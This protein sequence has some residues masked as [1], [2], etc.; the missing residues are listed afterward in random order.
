[1]LMK[2]IFLSII[3]FVIFSNVG[4]SKPSDPEIKILQDSAMHYYQN[5]D[6]HNAINCYN[7][8]LKKGYI[9]PQLYYNIGNSYYKIEDIANA[10]YFY[11]KA[12]LLSPDNSDIIHNLNIANSKIKNKV[13]PIPE[14]FFINWNKKFRDT[15][16]SNTW[17]LLSIILFV[18]SLSAILLYLFSKTIYLKKTGFYGAIIILLFSLIALIFS[19]NQANNITKNS[20]AIVFDSEIVKSSPQEEGSNLFEINEGLKVQ[21][22]DSLNS[23]YNIKLADGKQGWIKKSSVKRL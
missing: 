4:Y 18:I 16:S 21:I 10:I 17:A 8:I 15:L 19:I 13:N 14:L 3:I 23:F 6:Y 7:A 20:F 11:E 12:K 22:L 2:Q 5:N 1:M 9:S